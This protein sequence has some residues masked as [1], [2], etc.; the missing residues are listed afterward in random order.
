[1]GTSDEEFSGEEW[2]AKVRDKKYGKCEVEW[3]DRF[4]TVSHI[5]GGEPRGFVSGGMIHPEYMGSECGPLGDVV[6][7]GF[8]KQ[9]TDSVVLSF[10]NPIG[11]GVVGRDMYV[12]DPK[13]V[14]QPIKS[15]NIGSPI[16]SDNF[17]NSAPSAQDLLEDKRAKSATSLRAKCIPFGPGSEQ[18]ASLNNISEA[19]SQGH[20]HGVN[21]SLVE[22]GSGNG[23]GGQDADFNCLVKLA[24]ITCGGVPFD[25]LFKQRPP[26]LVKETAAREVNAFVTKIV[27]CI[28]DKTKLLVRRNIKLMSPITLSSPESTIE[29]EEVCCQSKEC[30]HGVVIKTW[31]EP[32]G[33]QILLDV[34]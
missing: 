2:L 18:A 24:L 13:F 23:D 26:E 25:V 9:R 19:R 14:G 6:F 8:D 1:M 28:V 15:S 22:E 16:I 31:C 7:A 29:Y 12:A 33:V 10:H 5:E 20:E 4:N 34:Y 3:E 11:F 32:Q 21:I 30:S 27:V 17:L